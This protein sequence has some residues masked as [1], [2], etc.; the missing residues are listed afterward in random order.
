MRFF[1]HQLHLRNA[2]TIVRVAAISSIVTAKISQIGRQIIAK[3][4]LQFFY[5]LIFLI[6]LWCST[7]FIEIA[8]IDQFV[9]KAHLPEFICTQQ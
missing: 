9:G 8:K 4:Q 7:Q 1:E 6:F 2:E 5:R 3:K